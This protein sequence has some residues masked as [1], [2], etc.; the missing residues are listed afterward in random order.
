M[1]HEWA[2]A[3]INSI[4]RHESTHLASDLIREAVAATRAVWSDVP[5]LGM[6]S[7]VDPTKVRRK[8]DP[9]RCFIRAGFKLVGRTKVHGLLAFQLLPEDMPEP[10]S[11]LGTQET[12]LAV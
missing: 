5:D 3:W 8:R 12:L 2:G 7:F 4:F 9:G 1:K 11:A 6:V 10:E